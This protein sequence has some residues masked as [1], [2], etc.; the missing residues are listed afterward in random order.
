[1]DILAQE[2]SQKLTEQFRRENEEEIQFRLL[3]QTWISGREYAEA[4]DGVKPA[5][6]RERE[7][8]RLDRNIGFHNE[9]GARQGDNDPRREAQREAE[10]QAEREEMDE[11]EIEE[12]EIER[13]HGDEFDEI[14]GRARALL[15]DE[16]NREDNREDEMEELDTEIRRANRLETR[17]Y[18]E[19][20]QGDVRSKDEITEDMQNVDITIQH[21]DIHMENFPNIIVLSIK[22]SLNRG[23]FVMEIKNMPA[24]EHLYIK[25]NIAINISNVPNLKSLVVRNCEGEWDIDIPSLQSVSIHQSFIRSITAPNLNYVLSESSSFNIDMQTLPSLKTLYINGSDAWN[26]HSESITHFRTKGCETRKIILPNAER[27]LI[28]SDI[29]KIQLGPDSTGILVCPNLKQY[30]DI[31]FEEGLTTPEKAELVWGT[32][33]MILY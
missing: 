32:Y 23:R 21:N 24:L 4:K 7:R 8:A 17:D 15:D 27:V 6:M 1:M 3:D 30:N 22:G 9:A 5:I 11:G 2:L 19:L 13:A 33:P 18:D 20:V 14:I 31:V 12:G 16:D 28:D 25:D 29:D 26:V 10:R